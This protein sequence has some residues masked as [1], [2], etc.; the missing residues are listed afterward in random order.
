MGDPKYAPIYLLSFRY[1][2]FGFEYTNQLNKQLHRSADA[3]PI[4]GAI[5]MIQSCLDVA[6]RKV[7][8]AMPSGLDFNAT[9]PVAMSVTQMMED[10]N[11]GQTIKDNLLRRLES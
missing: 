10:Y 6:H 1:T 9:N 5:E 11:L 8:N 7:A 2:K 4:N 3:I